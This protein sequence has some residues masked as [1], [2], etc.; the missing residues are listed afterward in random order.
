MRK[1]NRDVNKIVIQKIVDYCD[2]I[3]TFIRRFG[4]DFEDYRKDDAFQLS[5]SACII[6]IGELTTRLS[7]DFKEIHSNITWNAIKGL[8]NIHA[9]EYEH[10]DL[11]GMWNTLTQEIPELK[12]QLT[13]ILSQETET[14]S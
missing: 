7:E 8:R 13:E 6:Q 10:V 11:E 5:C 12:T 9:H 3:E 1:K 4:P 14:L 2:K